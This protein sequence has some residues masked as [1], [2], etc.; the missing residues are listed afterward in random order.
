MAQHNRALLLPEI[1]VVLRP[2]GKVIYVIEE[3]KVRQQIVK[4]GVRQEGF[5]EIVE[6]LQGDETV[7]LDGA[8]FLTD[9]A[10]IKIVHNFV[11]LI[12]LNCSIHK[13]ECTVISFLIVF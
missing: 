9:N 12:K 10:P 7:A 13:A 6:G 5:I 4:T 11:C 1:S 8:G 3:N 2:A